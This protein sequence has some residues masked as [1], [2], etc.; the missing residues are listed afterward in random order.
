MA[1]LT[2]VAGFSICDR[3]GVELVPLSQAVAGIQACRGAIDASGAD[4]VLVARTDAL[5]VGGPNLG[6][7]VERQVALSNAG[8]DVLCAPAL[9]DIDVIKGVVLA[10]AP[11]PLD[12][13]L[14]RPGITTMELGQGGDRR[15][16]VGDTFAEAA[17]ASFERAAKEFI[18]FGDLS[19]N[20]CALQDA[21]IQ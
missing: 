21:T 17:W 16:S 13:Q 6:A 7:T 18:D 8:A 12:V 20:C 14:V 15:V 10:V 9:A 5:L 3:I 19:S 11:K 4:V 2:G 1:I